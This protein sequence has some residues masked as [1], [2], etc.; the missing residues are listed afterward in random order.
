M[1]GFV[2]ASG[3][4]LV[5]STYLGGSK[6]DIPAAVA[7]DETG[8]TYVTGMTLSTNFPTTAD[9]YARTLRGLNDVFVCKLDGDGGL[10]YSTYVGGS[11]QDYPAALVVD[12]DGAAFVAGQTLSANFPTTTGALDHSFN[13]TSDAFVLE[14][15]SSAT[16]LVFS[17]LIGGAQDDGAVALVQDGAGQL[18]VL[19]STTSKD[20][21]TTTG[22]LD[23]HQ[24]GNNDLF[25]ACLDP[26]GAALT[27]STYLGGSNAKDADSPKIAVDGQ[28]QAYVLAETWDSGFPT[29]TGAYHT[30]VQGKSDL[31]LTKLN[32]D[33]TDLVYATYI[34]GSDAESAKAVA[35]DETGTAYVAG[36]S[37]SADFPTTAGVVGP[38]WMG[39]TEHGVVAKLDPSG[40]ELVFATYVG[41]SM[42]D[43]L[44]KMIL[45]DTGHC[46][47]LGTTTSSN[48]PV[49]TGAF[50]T[51]Y[52]ANNLFVSKLNPT[53][54][55]FDFSTF[56]GPGTLTPSAMAIDLTD[57][58]FVA[59]NTFY[60]G[61]P[62]TAGVFDETYNSSGDIYLAKINNTGTNLIFGTY[63]GGGGTESPAAVKVDASGNQIVLG[64]T[65]SDRYPT[66]SGAY[67][68]TFGGLTDMIL[69]KFNSTGTA[70]MYSTFIGESGSDIATGLALD[71]M[72]TAYLVGTT[73]NGYFPYT[74]GD[75]GDGPVAVRIN[76]EGTALTF[77]ARIQGPA[78]SPPYSLSLSA[79]ALDE[80]LKGYLVGTVRR[81]GFPTTPGVFQENI[82]GYSDLFI[83][84]FDFCPKQQPGAI[85]RRWHA[86]GSRLA[87]HQP[88]P[89]A[90]QGALS[91]GPSWPW[92][93]EL[94]KSRVAAGLGLKSDR[95][96]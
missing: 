88:R 22:A 5:F 87:L 74:N 79:M 1:S 19:G 3:S 86:H 71:E 60:T 23:T 63:L 16:G 47:L 28:G 58:V 4:A 78:Y 42:S 36:V 9:A 95:S 52:A 66:T 14:L 25:V 50:D 70:L 91:S 75:T 7:V 41:G 84:K 81:A 39:G 13:G 59:A 32:Q 46:Y 20:F 56:L 83:T 96:R 11:N 27:L 85:R 67:D 89:S 40:A 69:A 29:T 48:F 43:Q 73:S 77:A 2:L 80:D 54:S 17:T 34:G 18:L 90:S 6:A 35:V 21:P 64:I 45:D 55:A 51:S 37:A 38:T 82:A 26:S 10:I 8:A 76:A 93:S 94:N 57:A 49:T 53:A 68:R 30:A 72:G 12:S 44:A 65:N 33:A 61:A 92:P 31:I 62:V 24:D 15:D